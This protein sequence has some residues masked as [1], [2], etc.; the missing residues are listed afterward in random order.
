MAWTEKEGWKLSISKSLITSQNIYSDSTF[1]QDFYLHSE[2][3]IGSLRFSFYK[4]HAI[5]ICL[6]MQAK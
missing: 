2:K 3:N 4:I 1:V 6:K 5:Q